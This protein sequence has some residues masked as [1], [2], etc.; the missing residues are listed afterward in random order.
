MGQYFVS[1]WENHL[2]SAPVFYWLKQVKQFLVAYMVLWNTKSAGK[3]FRNL[4]E[5]TAVLFIWKCNHLWR[6]FKIPFLCSIKLVKNHNKTAWVWSWYKQ[7][8]VAHSLIS[9]AVIITEILFTR[10]LYYIRKQPFSEDLG[11]STDLFIL[12]FYNSADLCFGAGD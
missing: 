3:L 10:P 8:R 5:K 1:S 2:K 9:K 11:P 6:V 7:L 12:F 4:S